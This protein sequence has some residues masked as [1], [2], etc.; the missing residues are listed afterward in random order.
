MTVHLSVQSGSF[1]GVELTGG[2]CSNLG[3]V[4]LPY[5]KDSVH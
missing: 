4:L 3:H 5:M 2:D 1:Q